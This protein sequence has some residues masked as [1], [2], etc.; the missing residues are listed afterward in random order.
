MSSLFK[1]I[2]VPILCAAASGAAV[3]FVA[4]RQHFSTPPASAPAARKVLYYQ[5]AM[6]PW[7]KSDKPGRCTICGMELTPV[8]EGDKG[9][10]AGSDIVF[11]TQ[12]QVQVLHVQT[13]EAKKQPLT[14]TLL[15][16][17][18]IDDDDTRHRVLSAYTDGRIEKLKINFVGAE[19][20]AGQPLADIYSPSLLLAESE[21]VHLLKNASEP[22]SVAGARVKLERMGLG[23]VQ[24]EA[25]PEKPPTLSTS[26]LLAP[27][28]GTVVS[29]SVYEGQYVNMGQKLF[30]IADFSTMWFLFRAYEQDMPW[31]KIGQAVEV[32]T[33]SLPG[34][35]FAGS[36]TFIDPTFDE[37]TRST[38][39][40][41][42]LANPMVEGR[43]LL[44]HRLYADGNVRVDS[45]EV[46]AVPRSAV[47]DT[48]REAV[49]YVEQEGGAYARK[50]V[51]T[52]RHGNT[53][54]EIL[55][56]IEPGNRVVTNGN[57]LIDSQAEM[58]R[59]FMAPPEQSTPLAHS[60]ITHEQRAAL[61][62][63][64]SMADTLADALSMDDLAKFNEASKG[65]EP[66]SKTLSSV[67]KEPEDVRDEA[68]AVVANASLHPAKDLPE[69]R[70]E[71][72]RFSTAAVPLLEKLRKAGGAPEF[73]VWECYMVDRVIDGAPKTG[74]WVQ[75]RGRP[76]HNPFFGSDMLEC[77]KE[78]K[79]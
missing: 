57:L 67:M 9:F 45:P 61:S 56:G 23:P 63:F 31:I 48:G 35:I 70:V 54:V 50:P 2:T 73:Q 36:I 13:V 76:G 42:E 64:L 11:L 12:S 21:Y 51:R 1:S 15:V 25:L 78:I 33:P 41:V 18:A 27:M 28:G 69:A 29:K 6:H 14:R 58:N 52:G 7:V 17:G 77:A 26:E 4:G 62:E 38:N 75:T 68:V 59:S 47:I 72:H 55:G 34:K 44:L 3:W 22:A 46:L 37:A 5:S 16:A 20:T 40:R 39:V 19:V 43:R 74:R 79:P 71:F 53:L 10:D 66:L 32:T 60:T 30:E 65:A 24:I 8:Y 49:V